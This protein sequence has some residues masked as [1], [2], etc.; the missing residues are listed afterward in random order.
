MDFKIICSAVIVPR[1]T[2]SFEESMWDLEE[3]TPK[4]IKRGNVCWEIQELTMEVYSWEDHQTNGG[5]S[6]KPW[7]ITTIDSSRMM[8]ISHNYVQRMI[9]YFLPVKKKNIHKLNHMKPW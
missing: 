2:L 5:F 1:V 3:V 8:L 4:V 6:R 9:C 7:L